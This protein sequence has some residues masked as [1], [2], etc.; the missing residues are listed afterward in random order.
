MIHQAR[1]ASVPTPVIYDIDIPNTSI[2]MSYV[3]G[4]R[5]QEIL[6]KTP[7]L[8]RA[9]I[10]QFVGHCIGR[11]HAASIIHGDLTTSN[12]IKTQG[13]SI[14]L[15]DFGLS[16]HSNQIE[17]RGEDMHLLKNVFE[18]THHKISDEC[19]ANV[20]R[21]YSKTLGKKNAFIVSRKI[22]EIER[23]GR[24]NVGRQP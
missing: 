11:L 2:T 10:L 22:R 8:I 1:T 19:L 24:Y 9:R 20:M 18:S 7:R 4:P 15:I 12:M 3:E 23:R 13:D 16:F 17:D 14:S 6:E 5:L 21:G